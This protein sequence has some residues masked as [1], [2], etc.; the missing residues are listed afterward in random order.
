MF[1]AQ[2]YF[3]EKNK[4]NVEADLEE[5]RDNLN[6]KKDERGQFE[7]ELHEKQRTA[8]DA[9]REKQKL[10]TRVQKEVRRGFIN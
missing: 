8:K 2:L 6:I 5:L 9:H 3:A 7:S 1:L 10:E 4:T